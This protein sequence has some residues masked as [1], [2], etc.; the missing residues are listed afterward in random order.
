MHSLKMHFTTSEDYKQRFAELSSAG[1]LSEAQEVLEQAV[2][3]NHDDEEILIL[4]A[5]HYQE[6]GRLDD[7]IELLNKLLALNPRSAF[8]ALNLGHS[9]QTAGKLEEAIPIYWWAIELIPSSAEA[10]SGLGSA[11]FAC[12]RTLEAIEACREAVRIMPAY[13]EGVFNLANMLMAN[14]QIDEACISLHQLIAANRNLI[15]RLQ[16][17]GDQHLQA[18]R[19]PSATAIYHLA[20][21]L[22]HDDEHA[23]LGLSVSLS[24]N[25][26]LE[27]ALQTVD[28]GLVARREWI[29]GHWWKIH[30]LEQL[31]RDEQALEVREFLLNTLADSDSTFHRKPVLPRVLQITNPFRIGHLIGETDSYLRS[32]IRTLGNFRSKDIIVNY[33][34]GAIANASFL[35]LVESYFVIIQIPE[36]LVQFGNPRCFE[37]INCFPYCLNIGGRAEVYERHGSLPPDQLLLYSLP[38]SYRSA[39]HAMFQ[40]LN[41]PIGSTYVC[42]HVREGGYSPGD[43]YLHTARNASINDFMAAVEMLSSMGIYVIRMG[44]RSMTRAPDHPYLFD[45][46]LSQ[47]KTD[48]I[49]LALSA[50]TYFWLGTSSGALYMAVMFGRPIVCT[51]LAM[52]FCFGPT[53]APNHIGIP[54]LPRY[55]E[56]LELVPWP[57]FYKTRASEIR[58]S[59]VME[60]EYTLL[61]NTPEEILEV[62]EEMHLRLGGNWTSSIDDDRFQERLRALIPLDSMAY[63][64][65]SRCGTAFLRRYAQLLSS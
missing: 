32:K 45:Y 16:L 1:F 57:T 2:A 28:Q 64:T 21:A 49:D 42:L 19:L 25:N 43:E 31:G 29:A 3:R 40:A 52:P 39:R 33:A 61:D 7:V 46:A 56:T 65:A 4:L 53:G 14:S 11:L 17:M 51:N 27:G 35:S 20:L 34:C 54:K 60:E 15:P 12:G 47:Y 62:A 18:G 41:I 59:Q 44:D 48:E 6:V 8:A 36:I 37:T 30:V 50:D 55:K 58:F 22:N 38:D 5:R 26:D 10:H 24:F 63:G 13:A 9:L 23:R